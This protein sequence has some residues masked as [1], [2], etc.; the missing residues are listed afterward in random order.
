MFTSLVNTAGTCKK[1]AKMGQWAQRRRGGGGP[2]VP[3]AVIISIQAADIDT[4]TTV[5]LTYTGPVNAAVL[6]PESFSTL[7]EGRVGNDVQ[8][9]DATRVL[10]TLDDATASGSDLTYAGG[11]PNVLSPQT[12]E[13]T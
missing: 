5:E 11:A 13:I 12:I 9:L 2:P 7:P 10:L 3:A 1:A 8:Q 4:L 6:V